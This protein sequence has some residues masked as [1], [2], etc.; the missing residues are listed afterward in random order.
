MIAI[1]NMEK[2]THCYECLLRQGNCCLL[3]YEA[4]PPTA[5][6]TRLPDCPLIEIVRCGECK[7]V[8]MTTIGM[9]YACWHGAGRISENGTDEGKVICERIEDLNHFCSYGEK[10]DDEHMD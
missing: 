10:R 5:P 7:W 8:S 2:P 3:L 4:I 6:L 9:P 1:P